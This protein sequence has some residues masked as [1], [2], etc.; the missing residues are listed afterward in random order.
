MITTTTNKAYTIAEL[1]DLPDADLCALAAELR[2]YSFQFAPPWL[3]N[4]NNEPVTFGGSRHWSPPTDRTQSGE[5]LDWAW[6][7]H[8]V[9]FYIGF[10]GGASA[11]YV[12]LE[13]KVILRTISGT[14]ARSETIAFCAAR[15]AQ[16]GRLK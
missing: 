1:Q 16:Q 4:E 5:L 2:G 9:L 14:S 8:G 15:L 7:T 6:R 3:V 10:T 13:T 12:Q 11:G